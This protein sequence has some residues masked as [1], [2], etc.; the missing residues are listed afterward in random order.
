[1]GDW[2]R[3]GKA[4]ARDG[5]DHPGQI[6]DPMAFLSTL[7][8]SFEEYSGSRTDYVLFK[9]PLPFWAADGLGP[10]SLYL[11]DMRKAIA[12]RWTDYVLFCIPSDVLGRRRFGAAIAVPYGHEKRYRGFQ[13]RSMLTLVGRV[14]GSRRVRRCPLKCQGSLRVPL[15]ELLLIKPDQK[16][17]DEVIKHRVFISNFCSL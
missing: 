6:T 8:D 14:N 12:V 1:M 11:M 13:Q 4:S 9:A 15:D 17:S 10:P 2:I 5:V 7:W 3:I 16:T